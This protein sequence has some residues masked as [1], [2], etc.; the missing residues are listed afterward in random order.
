MTEETAM[1]L[2]ADDKEI[3]QVET[4]EG[5]EIV[6]VS[7]KTN[8]EIKES[9]FETFL[10]SKDGLFIDMNHEQQVVTFNYWFNRERE[11]I[12]NAALLVL[13]E[14]EIAGFCVTRPNQN[15]ASIG[16]I[17]VNPNFRR[18]GLAKVLLSRAIK[19]SFDKGV[20]KI[21]LEVATGNK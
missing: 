6:P 11:F 13:K 1:E 17:G 4:P 14:D 9:F 19:T 21:E 10:G 5:F 12:E 7:V 16:P 2:V 15:N 18:K 8:D 3:P 20:E